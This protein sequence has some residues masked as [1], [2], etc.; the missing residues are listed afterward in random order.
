MS[1]E[2]PPLLL[3]SPTAQQ[4]GNTLESWLH[5]RR[6][7]E[8]GELARSHVGDLRILVETPGLLE[9]GGNVNLLPTP[10]V[11]DQESYVRS[12]EQIDAVRFAKGGRS[13]GGARNLREV[14]V[15]E[16]GEEPQ[17]SS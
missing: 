16:L 4:S 1:G 5:R 10:Q 3:P 2:E 11:Y 8:T 15:N 7:M 12:Q 6:N 17:S 9:A 14:V 13:Q